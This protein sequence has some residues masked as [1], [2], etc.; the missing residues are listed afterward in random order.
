[1]K[2]DCKE[3]KILINAYIDDELPAEDR[4]LIEQHLKSCKKCSIEAESLFKTVNLIKKLDKI[5]APAELSEN[6]YRKIEQKHKA[7]LI[8]SLI[9]AQINNKYAVKILHAAALILCLLILFL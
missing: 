7:T 6:L 8:N 1:M 9:P 3:L 4:D 5:Q 2:L